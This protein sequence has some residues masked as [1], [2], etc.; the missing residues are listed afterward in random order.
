LERWSSRV[1][2][3]NE[4][5]DLGVHP[6]EGASAACRAARVVLQLRCCGHGPMVSPEMVSH[7][8]GISS[9]SQRAEG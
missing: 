8:H 6:G 9:I 3:V 7:E 2:Y 5:R 1:K 4:P